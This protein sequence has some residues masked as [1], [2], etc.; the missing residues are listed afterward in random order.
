MRI[1]PEMRRLELIAEGNASLPDVF[2]GHEK[3]NT[4]RVFDYIG[5]SARSWMAWRMRPYPL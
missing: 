4:G 3:R 2:A 1:K 5:K